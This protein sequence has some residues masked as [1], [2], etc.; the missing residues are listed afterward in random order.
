MTSLIAA[1]DLYLFNQG[2]HYRLYE[3]LG[4]HVVEGGTYFAV[5]APNAVTVSVI[6]DWNYWRAGVDRLGW[7]D[8]S[9]IWEGVVPNIGHGARYKFA[10][11]GP[12]NVTREKA[13]PFAAR[14]EHPPM[15]ASIIWQPTHAWGDAAWMADRG[16]RLARNA[17]V[18]IY[19]LHPGS[20]RRDHNE[21]LGYRAL[22]AQ[23]GAHVAALGFT[24]I[25]LMH[26]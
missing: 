23:L 3:K 21:V 17:P 8:S 10:I 18:S 1:E 14:A 4:A 7:R 25:E 11:V 12:D 15:T 24:H 5:W 26:T 2:T 16:A 13:D 19:E 6:G 9:G 22:G 20:W